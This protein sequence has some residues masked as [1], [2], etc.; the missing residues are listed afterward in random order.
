MS[1]LPFFLFVA[2]SIIVWGSVSDMA[3]LSVAMSV[4]IFLL[5]FKAGSLEVSPATAK[6][7]VEAT[8]FLVACAMLWQWG[9]VV[10]S[11]RSFLLRIMAVMPLAL[12]PKALFNT[13]ASIPDTRAKIDAV[14]KVRTWALVARGG[15]AQQENLDRSVRNDFVLAYALCC[16]LFFFIANHDNNALALAVSGLIFFALI[17]FGKTNGETAARNVQIPFFSTLA[18]MLA[19]AFIGIAISLGISFAYSSLEGGMNDWWARRMDGVYSTKHADTSI[20]QIGRARPNNKLLYRL[21]WGEGE[22]YLTRGSYSHTRNGASW[23]VGSGDEKTVSE[24]KLTPDS[25]GAFILFPENTSAALKTATIYTNLI[26]DKNALALPGGAYRIFGLPLPSVELNENGAVSTSGSQGFVKFFTQYNKGAFQAPPPSRFDSLVPRLLEKPVDLFVSSLGLPE[27]PTPEQAASAISEAFG[28]DWTYTLELADK[29]GN[30]RSLKDF[31]STDKRGHCEYFASASTLAMR[32]LGFPARYSTGFVVREF[33]ESE[34]AYW[35]RARNSHAW[36]SYWDGASWKILD[37]TPADGNADK[38]GLFEKAMNVVYML[39]YKID[40]VDLASVSKNFGNLP[41]VTVAIASLLAGWLL[42]LKRGR[43]RRDAFDRL[44]GEAETNCGILAQKCESSSDYLR[45]VAKTMPR[46][47]SQLLSL[48]QKR[49]SELFCKGG[50][51]S[52]ETERAASKLALSI[53]LKNEFNR[54]FLRQGRGQGSSNRKG[55]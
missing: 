41:S 26:R 40:S 15:T 46:W 1:R 17:I 35:I 50:V 23:T 16:V 52:I 38:E 45:R 12:F 11:E 47:E 20:G 48:A 3:V 6:R 34:R 42:F 13:I 30:P 54:I 44:I 36:A 18:A 10:D 5:S 53:N 51:P 49:E 24:K 29:N 21:Q 25:E 7:S 4:I 31:L 8:V 43:R 39:Q 19:A 27:N 32:R 33:N 55:P 37:S 14:S 22:G 2:C 28:R 9:V